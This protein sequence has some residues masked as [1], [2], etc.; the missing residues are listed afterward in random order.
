M[1]TKEMLRTV[2]NYSTSSTNQVPSSKVLL[3][4]ST[5]KIFQGFFFDKRARHVE[6][7]LKLPGYCALFCIFICNIDRPMLCQPVGHFR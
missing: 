6:Y 4:E 7:L 1:G 3:V 5:S 2:K